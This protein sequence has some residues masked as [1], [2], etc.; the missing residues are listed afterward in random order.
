MTTAKMSTL[1]ESRQPSMI[2]M[3]QIRFD[4]RNDGTEAINVAIGNVSLPMY[5]AM[6][7]RMNSLGAPGSPF[8]DGVVKYSAT[9]GTP[10]CIDA[11]MNII[12]SSG[13]ETSGLHGHITEGGTQAMELMIAGVCGE[14][15]SGDDPLMLIDAAYTNYKTLC[16]RLGRDTCSITRRLGDDGHFS[17]PEIDEI[18]RVILEKKP[19]AIIVIPFDNPTGQYYEKKTLVELAKLAVKHNLW[20]ISDEAYREL[21]YTSGADSSAPC[22]SIW[23]VTDQDA[24]GIEGRRVSIETT[25]KVWNACGLR[26]GALVTD[27]EKFHRKAIAEHTVSLCSSV[28]GQYIFGA[29]AGENHETLRGWYSKQR[30]YYQEMLFDF[31]EGMGKALPEVVVSSPQAALYSVI[32]VKNLVDDDF[33]ALDFVMWCAEEGSVTVDGQATTV[34]TAPMAGFYSTPPGAPNPGRTQM[35]VA[36]VASPEQMARIPELFAGLLKTYLAR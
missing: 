2:R 4:D 19:N 27:N 20:L 24:P 11:F 28:I 34:L 15:G 29:L 35:R 6:I 10:E 22:T 18:E 3:A 31:S 36:Y 21:Y 16:Q 12:A 17:M 1:F 14:P 8:A 13:F 23:G 26:I 25:S 32:D 9:S 7:E 30:T 33:Q 5:P